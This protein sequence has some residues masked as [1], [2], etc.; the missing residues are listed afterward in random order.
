M[1]RLGVFFLS[2]VDT[3]NLDWN[4]KLE[5]GTGTLRE[6]PASGLEGGPS[7]GGPTPFFLHS[8]Y[9]LGLEKLRKVSVRVRI[10][11]ERLIQAHLVRISKKENFVVISYEKISECKKMGLGRQILSCQGV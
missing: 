7:E 2:K 4:F 10:A 3:S 1:A 6:S 5:T 9:P 11:L 8:A